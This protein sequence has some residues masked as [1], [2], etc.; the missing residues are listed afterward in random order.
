M[1]TARCELNCVSFRLL[2]VSGG[3]HATGTQQLVFFLAQGLHR[4]FVCLMV[5]LKSD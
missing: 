1:F 3:L 2:F 5:Q 4:H